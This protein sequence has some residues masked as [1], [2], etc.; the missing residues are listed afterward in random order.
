M[1]IQSLSASAVF[2]FPSGAAGGGVPDSAAAATKRAAAPHTERSADLHPKLTQGG[3]VAKPAVLCHSLPDAGQ[4]G[5]QPVWPAG[6]LPPQTWGEWRLWDSLLLVMRHKGETWDV[7]SLF[8][9]CRREERR[10]KWVKLIFT[11]RKYWSS[12]PTWIA[13]NLQD[14]HLYHI[15][16]FMNV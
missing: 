2:C 10:Q 13:V 1:G 9:G 7:V 3:P 4:P 14:C 15:P 5:R 11:H 8:S 6:Q 12:R 16:A